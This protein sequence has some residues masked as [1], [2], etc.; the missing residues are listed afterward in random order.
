M[1]SRTS[2]N[3][4][5]DGNGRAGPIL[6][7]P[8]HRATGPV[9]GAP[10]PH[11]SARA[12]VT[13]SAAFLDDIPPARGE[14]YAGV[15]GSPLA[16]GRIVAVDTE[17]A[18][19]VEGV[20]AVLTAADIPGARSFGPVVDDEELLALDECHHVG[21]P[22]VLVAAETR[23]ALRAAK[24]A[25]RIEME[26]LPAVLTIDEAIAG[27]HTLGTPRRVARGD[28]AGALAR[29]EHV[30]EGE[31][32]AG[33]QEHFYLETQAARA[34]PCD[35][36]QILV[37]SSTQNPSEVQSVVARVLGLPYCQVVCECR[38]M[39]G[40]FGGK[41]TQAA[42]PAALAALV[43]VKTGRPARV[44]L[45][46]DQDMQAT[47]KRHPYLARYRVGFNADGLITALQMDLY[48]DGGCTL[49]LSQAVLDRSV[50][51]AENAYF[52]PNVAIRGTVCRT[53]LP[54]NT[55]FRGFGGPQAVAAMENVI[56]EVATRLGLDPLDVRLRNVYGGPGRDVTPY[57][58]VLPAGHT[59]PD[60]VDGLARSSDYRARRSEL[61]AFNAGSRTHLKGQALTPVKFGISF[62]RRTL[63]QGNALVNLYLD[64][65]VQVSTGGTEMGQGLNTKIRQLV[66]G[67]F[68][69]PVGSV[70]VMTTST[71]K[72]NNTSPTAASASTDL[73][74]TAAVR[75]CEVLKGRLAGVAAR[76]LAAAA[77]GLAASPEH[78]V[79]DAGQVFDS[80]RPDRRVGF[81]ELVRLAY[82]ERVD[83]GARG[84]YATPGVDFNRETGRGHP[85]YYYTT[86][87]AAAEVLVDRLTGE[88]KVTRVDMLM[89]IGRSI[90]PAVDRGQVVGGFVQGMGWVT[91]EDVRYSG[92]GAL[93]SDGPSTYKIPAVTDVPADFRVAF[94][95]R[96][97]PGNVFGSKAVGEPPLLLAVSVWAAVKDALRAGAPGRGTGLRLPATCEEVLRHLADWEHREEAMTAENS[98]VEGSPAR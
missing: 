5:A 19:R 88:V 77:E 11:E 4:P 36:G 26:P 75:A 29:A 91:T 1:P 49:D 78:V 15:V 89:D 74:G 6:D 57:G 90:N 63:N 10:L 30:L 43:A 40:G 27:G 82:E 22:V 17:A 45:D 92:A 20:V 93:L 72:N 23:A 38:R 53:N 67:E 46:R 54:S 61:A 33:G 31:F 41:E 18:A 13:G 97:N 47:G 28:V 51:H 3:G 52:I 42:G 83:L 71:E 37:Q 24:A 65:T 39:G 64:G 87:A 50:L 76:H 2:A 66:A 59:L 21:Q 55:A 62:T 98:K 60:V 35:G 79:F 80:R 48:S 8:G 34:V 85:F 84:F 94:L 86:G 56:E 73:N 14:L 7:G 58:Q 12:H 96:D 70:Q 16:H 32:R 44:V 69:L 68:G 81:A 9:L 95:D 25:V